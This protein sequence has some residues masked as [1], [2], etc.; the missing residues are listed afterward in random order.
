MLRIYKHYNFEF[1]NNE[2]LKAINITFSSY[3][4][5]ISSTDDFYVINGQLVVLETTLE[6]LNE[7]AYSLVAKDDRYIPDFMRIM[8]N[9]RLAVD[10]E[11]WVKWLR[12]VNTGTYN[13][14]WMIIDMMKFEQSK[15]T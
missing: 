5:T 4:G 10:A 13:S 11:D 8:I 9:N 6:I 3:P 1:F 15:G 7:N 2:H 12:Y 14:Q